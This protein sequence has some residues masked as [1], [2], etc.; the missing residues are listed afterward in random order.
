MRVCTKN[1]L[2][3][4]TTSVLCWT[5]VRSG[6]SEAIG[7]RPAGDAAHVLKVVGGRTTEHDDRG[8]TKKKK[9][10]KKK[11][12]KG[13]VNVVQEY[14]TANLEE[15]LQ[16]DA[17][18]FLEDGRVQVRFDFSKQNKDHEN[19][20]SPRI[21]RKS[22]NAFRW[23][24]PREYRWNYFHTVR[25]NKGRWGD[26]GIHIGN[27]G[28]AVLNCWFKDNVVAEV[29][30]LPGVSY[31]RRQTLALIFRPD[32]GKRAIGSNFGSQC[33]TFKGGWR[34]IA[35]GKVKE[36]DTHVSVDI[37]LKVK[38][39]VFEASK[40]GKAQAEAKYR[41]K[42]MPSGR[43]GLYWAGGTAGFIRQLTITGELDDKKMLKVIRKALKKRR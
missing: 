17:V 30:Y 14:V 8:R 41:T 1:I 22:Q 15:Y 5:Q 20:F 40:N 10:K 7:E 12:N 18:K 13:A 19:L 29:E 39:G 27:R 6:E 28:M 16:A 24:L 42:F 9:K 2:F 25:N 34:P 11:K 36:L 38:D 23:A 33:V 21:G 26:P 3:A 35:V 37:Q 31:N 32:K 43:V 4:L